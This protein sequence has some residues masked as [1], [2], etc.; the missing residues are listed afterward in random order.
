MDS[1]NIEEHLNQIAENTAIAY[2]ALSDPGLEGFAVEGLKRLLIDALDSLIQV[3]RLLPMTL[4]VM[5]V[6]GEEFP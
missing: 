2:S 6:K 3:R 4:L 5:D 1:L